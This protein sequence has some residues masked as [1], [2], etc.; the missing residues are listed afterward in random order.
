MTL[1]LVPAYFPSGME[2]ASCGAR[3]SAGTGGVEEGQTSACVLS[4]EIK[5]PFQY[6]KRKTIIFVVGINN[7]NKW[8]KTREIAEYE[9]RYG[10]RKVTF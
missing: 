5:Y 2:A 3:Q 6:Y 7:S 9:G 1:L 10:R 4:S 8:E